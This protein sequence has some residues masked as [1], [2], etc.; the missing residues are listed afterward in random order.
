M[1]KAFMVTSMLCSIGALW[2][3][4]A[5][6]P[7]ESA[8]QAPETALP[9]PKT[10][11]AMPLE[12]AI[13][14]RRSVRSYKPDAL[15]SEQL[16][17]ILWSAQGLSPRKRFM[18]RN[19]PSAGGIYPLEVYVFDKTGIYQYLA[20]SHSLILVKQG[21]VRKSLCDS[22]YGQAYIAQAP[23][24][25][26]LAGD[27]AKCAKRYGNRAPR[28]IAMEA[29]HVGQNISLEAVALGLGAVMIGAFDD[30]KANEVL[31]LPDNLSVFYII[32]VGY[33]K[34]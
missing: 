17:Q 2:L 27:V 10:T 14:K 6:K 30:E 32:P 5:D 23:V 1:E 19:A 15:T 9:S 25:I 21:D 18:A 11:G 24:D 12:E 4:A 31:G 29:G 13:A 16:S 26:V 34:E 20:K 7:D 33:P 28:Y 3:I 8:K 22:A